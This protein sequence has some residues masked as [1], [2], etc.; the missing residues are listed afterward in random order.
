MKLL[1][2]N[3]KT[4]GIQIKYDIFQIAAI[5]MD[6]PSKLEIKKLPSVNIY[7]TAESA[8]SEWN[9][10]DRY[11]ENGLI[12]KVK[13]TSTSVNFD[14][15]TI[16]IN[17]FINSNFP[18]DMQKIQLAGDHVD[19]DIKFIRK[20]LPGSSLKTRA[21]YAPIDIPSLFLIPGID[22][23]RPTLEKCIERT[24]RSKERPSYDAMEDCLKLA[25]L[26]KFK[27]P[28]TN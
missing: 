3:T 12:E 23:Y 21:S 19:H 8:N 18:F 27:H 7:I 13:S 14:E 15:A 17:H 22:V 2:I 5:A 28:A 10:L 26:I 20:Y 6:M 16:K 9:L 11:K 1:I 24:G 25:H 4:G